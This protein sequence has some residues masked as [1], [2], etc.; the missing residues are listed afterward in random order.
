M[1]HKMM[2]HIVISMAERQTRPDVCQKMA[3]IA[4][5]VMS[6]VTCWGLLTIALR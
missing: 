4:F 5:D 2:S 3:Y 1:R 6:Q